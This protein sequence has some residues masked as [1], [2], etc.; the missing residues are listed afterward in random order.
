MNY[1][2]FV[3]EGDTGRTEMHGVFSALHGDRLGTV[4]WFGLWRQY[5]FFPE[6]ETVWNRDCLRQLAKFLDD[7]MAGQELRRAVMAQVGR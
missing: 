3:K 7:S 1:L 4:K 6:P 2:K 5:A